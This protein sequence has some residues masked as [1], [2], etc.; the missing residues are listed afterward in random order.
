MQPL[1]KNFIR[2][3]YFVLIFTFVVIL[4]GG[5]VRTT[6]SGMGCPD[7]P[8]CFG[9]WIPP[10]TIN[11][12]PPNYETYL[13]QQDID[14]TFNV[15]HTWV[16]YINRLAGALLGVIIFI[17]FIW[18]YLSF[19]KKK[20]SIFYLSLA[21]LLLTGFQGW[22]GKTVVDSNLAVVKITLHMLVAII[23]AAIPVVIVHLL[24]IKEK[25][26][27]KIL[28]RLATATLVAVVL[29]III[30]TDVREQIDEIA[31]QFNY[32]NRPAWLALVDKAFIT[33]RLF[34]YI[35]VALCVAT[36]VRSF[37]HLPTKN[38][39]AFILVMIIVAFAVGTIL[40]EL[41]M[42]P[43][44]QPVH[45]LIAAMLAVSVFKLRLKL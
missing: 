23:I 13:K 26:S 30:G 14:H 37:K 40:A 19:F 25:I 41:D 12:L 39:G 38:T 44:A 20:R 4:A 3:T 2:Y 8:T 6:Q 45:M 16:E 21:M 22:L 29:Q 7:W 11:D 15:Y 24:K 42:P 17:H 43:L 9:K 33:H 35:V 31:K 32:V 28:K 27:D 1:H 34:A 10:L 18:S 5:V 36:A